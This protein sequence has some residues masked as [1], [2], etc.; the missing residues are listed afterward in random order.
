MKAS[1]S[2]HYPRYRLMRYVLHQISR[3]VFGLLADLRISGAENIPPRGPLLVVGNHFSFVDPVAVVCIAPWPM[4]FVAGA[5]PPHAPK[6][7]LVIP[8][9]WRVLPLYRGTGSTDALKDAASILSQNGVLGIFPEGGNWA[10][11]LRPARPGTA[12]LASLT[13]AP[14]LP[15]GLHGLTDVLPLRLGRRPRVTINIGKIFGPFH[16]T[17]HGRERRAQLDEIG[18]EI[19]RR[20]AELLPPEKRGHYSDDPAIRAAAQGTEIYPWADK[21]E[22]EVSGE[23]R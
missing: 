3:P 6:L 16:A 22:G 4:E 2:I 14:I 7:S 1:R 23:I 9:L 21:V 20:I 19:M 17:G 15:I 18:H 12:F 13:G 11:V 8:W 10:D 5:H